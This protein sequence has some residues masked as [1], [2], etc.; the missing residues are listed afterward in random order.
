MLDTLNGY[1]RLTEG[2]VDVIDWGLYDNAVNP[3]P[4]EF[5]KYVSE[6]AEL[7]NQPIPKLKRLSVDIE[8]E[9]EI[10]RIPDPK[11]AEKKVTAIG[12]KGSNGFDQI[13]DPKRT[14]FYKF[15][16]AIVSYQKMQL[17][18]LLLAL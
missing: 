16:F 3:V 10:G 6:W 4:E 2:V 14:A 17:N 1:H 18:N 13:F 11:L 8:V 9:A 7:L 5:K 12:L 15:Y